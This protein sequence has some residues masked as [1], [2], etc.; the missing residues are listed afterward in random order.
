[1]RRFRQELTGSIVV[2]LALIAVPGCARDPIAEIRAMHERGR[3]EASLE[4][5]ERLLETRRDDAEVQYLY[6]LANLQSGRF[7]LALWP[8]RRASENPEW[9]V[10]AGQA[11]AEAALAAR[12]EQTAIEAATRVL[13]KEPDD[14]DMLNV[15]A[16]A[17]LSSNRFAEALRDVERLEAL[18]PGDEDALVMRLRCLIGED[19]IDDAEKLFAELEKRSGEQDFPGVIGERYCA[20]RAIFAKEKDD[21]A[22]AERRFEDCL[23]AFPGSALVVREAIDFF[24]GLSRSERSIEILRAALAREP[25]ESGIREILA[26]RLRD[27]G[28][29]EEAEALLL[30]GTQL[31]AA[32]AR[33]EAWGGLASHYFQLGDYA[34]SVS[35]WEE[36][37]KLVDEPGPEDLFGYAEALLRAASYDRAFEVAEKLPDANAAFVRGLVLLEQKKPAEA[38]QHFEAGLRLWPNHA[39]ARRYAAVAAER[40]G[41]HDRA[42]AEYRQS[43]RSGAGESDAGLRLAELHEAEGASERAY[44]AITLYLEAHPD[45]VEANVAALR[46]GAERAR[47]RIRVAATSL[48]EGARAPYAAKAAEIIARYDGAA[49]AIDFLEKVEVDFTAPENAEALRALVA[50]LFAAGKGREARARVEKALAAHSDAASFHAI[51]ALAL[52]RSAAPAAEVRAEYTRAIELDPNAAAALAALGRLEAEAGNAES[53]RSFYSRAVAADPRDVDARRKAAE[54]AAAAGDLDDAQ[55]RWE[56]LLEDQPYDGESAAKRAALLVQRRTDPE[57]ARALA[58]QAVRFGGGPEAYALL[59]EIHLESGEAARAVTAL[60]AAIEHRPRDASLRY[61]LGRA[62]AAAGKRDA[63]REAFERA[64]AAGEFPERSDAATA[65]AALSAKAEGG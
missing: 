56:A 65:L 24:D 18:D 59:V 55:K 17:H 21:A 63:A 3:F 19:R 53:A 51:R 50:Q 58:R 2:V 33:Y 48:P 37:L 52:E 60:R 30:E 46:I 62:L 64:L 20:A 1:M 6:G 45:D 61:Q 25:S 9:A 13:E 34:K 39:V 23:K 7:S 10:R 12:D 26:T 29:A 16:E 43:I 22:L 36:V 38:L 8:L 44:Q 40:A 35:A 42:I 31:D 27:R 15:R 11:L 57:R 28:Q 14:R 47:G 32:P 4:P 41:D 5:L 54:L 49:A